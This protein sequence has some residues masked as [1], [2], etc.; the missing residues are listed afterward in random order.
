[1][2]PYTSYPLFQLVVEGQYLEAWRYFQALAAPQP[3]EL[4]FAGNCLHHLGR[5]LE[6][7]DLLIKAVASGAPTAN[8]ELATL[9]R[10]G[11]ECDKAEQALAHLSALQLEAFDDT[12]ALRERGALAYASGH[13]PQARTFLE[14]AWRIV[15]ASEFGERLRPGIAQALALIANEMGLEAEA[16][17]YCDIALSSALIPRRALVLATKALALTNIGLFTAAQTSLDELRPLQCTEPLCIPF[18]A[19]VQGLLQCAQ[20]LTHDALATFKCAAEAAQKAEDRETECF[21]RLQ[22][23]ACLIALN[24]LSPARSEIAKVSR[25]AQSTKTRAHLALREGSLFAALGTGAALPRLETAL[26]QF[27]Q[28]GLKREEGL[29]W[30]HIAHNHLLQEN[31]PEAT[32]ALENAMDCQNLLEHDATLAFELWHLPDVHNHLEFRVGNG[33]AAGLLERWRGLERTMP[34]RLHLQTLGEARLLADGQPVKF[35]HS[36]TEEFLAYVLQNPDCTRGQLLNALKPDTLPSKA[37]NYLHQLRND[38]EHRVKGLHIAFN[39]ETKRYRVK[40]SGARLTW[41][42]AQ[43]EVA[44]ESPRQWK[45]AL[46][47]YKGEFVPDGDNEWVEGERERLKV[48][49]ARFVEAQLER[50]NQ[51]CDFENAVAIAKQFL[52]LE[53]DHYTCAKHYVHAMERLHGAQSARSAFKEIIVRNQTVIGEASPELLQL[54]QQLNSQ[55]GD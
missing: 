18:V 31:H 29:T 35:K 39:E 23:V 41:D 27:K 11:G 17:H 47:L 45:N 10:L 8:I 12:L 3:L 52:T 19:Y 46:E 4:R 6:A 26:E 13:L 33:Y 9:Y 21:A 20:G 48:R 7:K 40:T 25:L 5:S 55:A 28:L 37:A 14:Q 53:P 49:V 51:N 1:M 34:A 30:L 44:L 2:T 43:L 36:Q 24:E 22:T 50:L 38:L 16:V 42:V 15:N 54:E 32:H